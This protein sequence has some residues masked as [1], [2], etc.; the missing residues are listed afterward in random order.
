[1]TLVRESQFPIEIFSLRKIGLATVMW[2]QV[3]G[4][5]PRI[6]DVPPWTWRMEQCW[7]HRLP[8]GHVGKYGDMAMMVAMMWQWQWCTGAR[9]CQ[10]SVVRLPA[11]R[12]EK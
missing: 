12:V 9:R 8:R 7:P 10:R 11:A 6:Y 4:P 2:A 5:I 1:M 3:Y